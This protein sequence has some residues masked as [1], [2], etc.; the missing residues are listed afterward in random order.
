MIKKYINITEPECL[1]LS[2]MVPLSSEPLQSRNR[3]SV[4]KLW[5]CGTTGNIVFSYTNENEQ[6]E[7]AIHHGF[8][9]Y[10]TFRLEIDHAYENAMEVFSRRLPSTARDDYRRILKSHALNPDEAYSRFQLLSA[11]GGRLTTD[12]YEFIDPLLDINVGARR[13]FDVASVRRYQD[14]SRTSLAG[15]SV[16]FERDVDNQSD[17]FAVKILNLE[18]EQIGWVNRVQSKS[19]A[20]FLNTGSINASVFRLNGRRNYPRVFALAEFTK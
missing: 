17:P 12:S 1:I 13:L 19:V 4:G 3:Y 2:W 8:E 9:G 11:T 18:R 16:F 10:P 15:E 14:K 6:L 20:T 5:R 7:K